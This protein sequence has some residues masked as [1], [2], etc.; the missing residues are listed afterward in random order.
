MVGTVCYNYGI[1][2]MGIKY[3]CYSAPASVSYF[4]AIPFLIA[5]VISLFLG[6]IC[7][8]K[9]KKNN[10]DYQENKD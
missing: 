2:E 10:G 5:I 1:M 9:D 7:G 6:W 8:R 4:L 3:E